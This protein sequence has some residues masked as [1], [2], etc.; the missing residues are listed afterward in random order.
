MFVQTVVLDA[1]WTCHWYV[2]KLAPETSTEILAVAPIDLQIVGAVG[3]AV[4][5]LLLIINCNVVVCGHPLALV[6]T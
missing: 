4:I 1:V 3:W 5:A 2:G 6:V